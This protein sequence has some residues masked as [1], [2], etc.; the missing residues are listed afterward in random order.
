MSVYG[1]GDSDL[2]LC[3]GKLIGLRFVTKRRSGYNCRYELR[4]LWP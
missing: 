2:R 1:L 4:E 3:V